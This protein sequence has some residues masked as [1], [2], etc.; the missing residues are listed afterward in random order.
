MKRAGTRNIFFFFLLGLINDFLVNIT[1]KT[2]IQYTRKRNL[3]GISDSKII[4]SF[5]NERSALGWEEVYPSA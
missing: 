4:C 2:I 3:P 1:K 5:L